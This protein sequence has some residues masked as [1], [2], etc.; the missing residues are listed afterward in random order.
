MSYLL[1]SSISLALLA[2]E[3]FANQ[4]H[5]VLRPRMEK[6]KRLR[7]FCVALVAFGLL[8]AGCSS[9]SGSGPG[10]CITFIREVN[11]AGQVIY[12]NGTAF[13]GTACLAKVGSGGF[14]ILSQAASAIGQPLV[15]VSS[16]R[17]CPWG[18]GAVCTAHSGFPIKLA[19]AGHEKFTFVTSEAHIAPGST[20]D[21]GED[22]FYGFGS[23][24]TAEAQPVT[25][26]MVIMKYRGDI[27]ATGGKLATIAGVRYIVKTADTYPAKR[28]QFVRVDQVNS[29]RGFRL[30]P[31]EQYAVKHG[32]LSPKASQIGRASC[33]ERV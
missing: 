15:A 12:V 6:V 11:A 16:R 7:T 26:L 24:L 31:L 22:Q 8:C 17:G 30:G 33:R 18:S 14:R 9:I 20:Y 10:T 3:R 28:I 23:P 21:L 4:K 25:E 2:D 27:L 13:G 32:W 19:N 5:L 1:K 29:L